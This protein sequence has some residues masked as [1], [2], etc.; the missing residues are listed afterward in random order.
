LQSRSHLPSLVATINDNVVG[1]ILG[2]ASG[3]EFG[4]PDT[5]GWIHTIGVDPAAQKKGVARKLLHEMIVHLKKVGVTSIYVLV[6]WRDWDLL[7]FLDSA[8]FSRGDMINL[9][10]K[11]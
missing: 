3:W 1:F 7:K 10:L 4:I 6:S 5:V 11:V 2:E 8:G 9:E